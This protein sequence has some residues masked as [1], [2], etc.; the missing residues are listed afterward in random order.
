MSVLNEKNKVTVAKQNKSI[1]F[2]EWMKKK[3]TNCDVSR[4]MV[5]ASG[6]DIEWRRWSAYIQINTRDQHFDFFQ[7]NHSF[8]KWLLTSESKAIVL[9]FFLFY[10]IKANILQNEHKKNWSTKWKLELSKMNVIDLTDENS[11]NCRSID[12]EYTSIGYIFVVMYY[13]TYQHKAVELSTSI[14]HRVANEFAKN[15]RRP[16][17][18]FVI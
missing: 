5:E 2:N 18:S 11:E 8:I 17:L 6:S 7:K 3:V 10:Y 1:K 9:F 16:S 4:I 15:S 13:H 12:D 14:R